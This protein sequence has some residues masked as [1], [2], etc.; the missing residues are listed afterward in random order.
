LCCAL[1]AVLAACSG[2]ITGGNRAGVQSGGSGGRV[3]SA[4]GGG[5]HVSVSGGHSG[6][7]VATMTSGDGGGGGR[8][9]S[10]GAGAHSGAG[11][12]SGAGARSGSSGASGGG[13]AGS[14]AGSGTLV[15]PA[16][17]SKFFVGANFWNVDWEG[18]NDY[19]MSN[20]DWSS[21]TN[22]WQPQ[23]LSDLAP[24]SVLRF[25]DWNQIND[26]PNPQSDWTTRTQK[27]D[28]Q[29]EPIAFEW[30]IDLCNR[31]K[32]DYWLNIPSQANSDYFGKLA[33]LI[34]DQLDPSLRVYVEWSNEVWNGSFP[35]HAY[36]QSQ[37]KAMKLAGSDGASSFQV[38][39]SVR[40]FEAF[41]SVF[42][43]GS[44]RLVKVIAG[45]AA[46]TGP[47]QAEATAFQDST[48]NPNGTKADA[49]AIAPY[50]S[51]NSVDDLMNSGISEATGY[52]TDSDTCAKS[53]GWPLI[54]YEGGEDSYAASGNGCTQLQHDAG[55][56]D[57]YMNYLD[58][59]AGAK[60]VGP[61]MQYTHSGQCWGLKEKTSDT[62]A[63]SPKY[64]GVIDW[65]SAH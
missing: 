32:K 64:Q 47:C 20:V 1:A 8:R 27:T 54:S 36:A 60:L 43:K 14:A 10:A 4:A 24:Y 55:M 56:H 42:G 57:V 2:D 3:S 34:H 35:Q 22:P 29:V 19:F 28:N 45:Q 6:S 7:G 63:N 21:T 31:A 12:A 17:G 48:I 44:P 62:L 50:F 38:Y 49:Y 37:A 33:Q 26:D 15:N 61:F 58:A 13:A 51:G 11:G 53:A 23:L 40:A 30:Q 16:P 39:Q 65:L 41:E 9:G 59:M 18:A 46:Y 5:G 52:V 25:M